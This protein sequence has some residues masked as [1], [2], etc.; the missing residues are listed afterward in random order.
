[1]TAEKAPAI[2]AIKRH[3]ATAFGVL[4]LVGALYVVQREFRTLSWRDIRDALH[5]TPS[6]TLLAAA[7]WTVATYAVLSAYDR[8]GSIYAGHPVSWARSLLAS[9]TAYALANNLGFATVSG[10][11]VRYRF[12]AAWGLPPVAIAKVVAFTSL[13]FGLG[14]FTLIGLVLIVEPEMLRFVVGNTPEWVIQGFGLLLW[15]VVAAYIFLS[16]F[17][18]HFT[19]F[20]HRVDLP[21]MRMAVAQT[22]LASADVAMTALIFF[23]L[24]PPTEGL[25]FLHFLGIYVVA[26][27]AGMAANVPGGIGVFDGAMMLGLSA[28]LPTPQ[29]VGALLLFRLYYYIIPLFVA[30]ALFAAFEIGQRR[31][32]IPA[33]EPEQRVAMTFEVPVL[34]GLTSL[35]AVTLIFIGALPPPR[36]AMPGGALDLLEEAGSHFAAS[37]VG[38]LLLAAAYG[39]VRRLSLA[40]WVTLLLLLNGAFIAWLRGEAWWLTG[41][42]L[43]VAL[44]LSVSKASFYRRARILTEPIS[45]ESAIA[46]GAG[47]LCAITL[48]TVAYRGAVSDQSWWGVVLSADAPAS[49]RFA[50]GAAGV[51]L[52][53]AAVRLLRP[54]RPFV[55]AWTP[56]LRAR[57]AVWGAR[58]PEEAAGA[59]LGAAGAAGVAF[60]RNDRI[61]IALGDP[62]GEAQD[63]I[64]AIWRF[65]DA[66]D[67]GGADPAFHGVGAELLR[68]YEDVGLT[69]F[70]LAP[71][72]DGTPLYLVCRAERDLEALMPLLPA[73]GRAA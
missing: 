8:L 29:V 50:V 54:A 28:F 26:F 71:R 9:F 60:I 70:P 14:G 45:A 55:L 67:R 3:A 66:C 57:L 59:V 11:A 36:D 13:T 49:L 48:A 47:A 18:P 44:L 6:L 20:G 53:Y 30:G 61:W 37:V 15:S 12:Y 35:A 64:S 4:L 2:G 31:H 38:S 32:L 56:E 46:L 10:A 34:A 1:M 63:R 51:F 33:F 40:W 68:V 72:A 23:V 22:A 27:T 17:I 69:A 25:T 62:A 24:L 16:R 5:A 19:L 58:A 7:G 43:L 21:G 39:L 42:F 52:L 65:R 41:A 73:E